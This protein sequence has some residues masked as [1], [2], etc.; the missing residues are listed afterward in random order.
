MRPTVIFLEQQSWRGGAQRVLESTLSALVPTFDCI[1]AFPDSGPFRDSLESRGIET[2][3]LPIGRCKSGTK[4]LPEVVVMA[5]RGL[6]GGLRL[7]RFARKRRG[8][9]IY[10][11]G[12]RY[13]LTGVLA[14]RLSRTPSIFHLH[15]VLGRRFDLAVAAAFSRWVSRVVAC[16]LAAAAPLLERRPC[17]SP[18]TQVIY[19]P[20]PHAGLSH[21]PPSQR[22]GVFTI[23]IVAR[24]TES[25][26]HHVLL[27]AVS[28]LPAGLREQIRLL[29]IGS[30]APDCQ[31]D[32]A[33][34]QQL[35]GQTSRIGLARQVTWAGYQDDPGP[36]YA[37]MNVL[38]HPAQNEA[39]CLV[40]LE[41]LHR[42]VPVI[43]SR[44]GGIPEVVAD[45]TNGLLVEPNDPAALSRA[46]RRFAEDSGL[47][48]H[49]QAGAR[50]WND[51]RFSEEKF[52]DAIRQVVAGHCGSRP[53]RVRS[54]GEREVAP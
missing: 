31:A 44:T 32:R 28:G 17:R 5:V 3:T 20:L 53:V 49:L 19:N 42:G 14:A 50:S 52:A 24:I 41:A 11:N 21:S 10:I 40:I 23:G 4:P 1:V 38:V 22:K 15:L 36:W 35:R 39:M 29:F 16:S 33:Y 18:K 7:A 13:L 9:L 54:A 51:K 6:I 45:G 37:Q 48:E 26:G 47:R 34:E 8:A 46:L 43:A 2:V 12:P 25:K 27:D 30:A